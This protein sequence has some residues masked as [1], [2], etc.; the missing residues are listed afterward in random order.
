MRAFA[1][2]NMNSQRAIKWIVC[3]KWATYSSCVNR[4]QMKAVRGLPVGSI[5]RYLPISCNSYLSAKRHANKMTALPRLGTQYC[6]STHFVA[7]VTSSPWTI[8][9]SPQPKTFIFFLPA[10]SF[11]F[12]SFC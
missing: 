3:L 2:Y 1:Y 10:F 6:F 7:I 5:A 4:K 11:F 8:N 12:A 9:H